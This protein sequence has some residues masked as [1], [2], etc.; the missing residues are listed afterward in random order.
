MPERDPFDP[1][2]ALGLAKLD[3]AATLDAA[4]AL[5]TLPERAAVLGSPSGLDRLLVLAAV[6][7][8]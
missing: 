5:L 7:Q 3:E 2:L 6:G 8:S 4:L 1:L